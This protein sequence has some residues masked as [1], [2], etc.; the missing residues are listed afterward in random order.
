MS[1]INPLI[2]NEQERFPYAVAGIDEAGRGALAGPVVVS[3]VILSF[4]HPLERLNDSKLL[5]PRLRAELYHEIIQDAAAYSIIEIDHHYID[6]HNILQACF[7]GMRQAEQALSQ[8]AEKLII[9]GNMVPPGMQAEAIVKGDSL[10]ASIAA[11]SILAK[12]PRDM[13]MI[14]SAEFY[15]GYHFEKHKGYGTAQHIKAITSLGPSP[16]HRLSFSPLSEF[17]IWDRLK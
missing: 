10:F 5:N 8:K 15:P 12:V 13:L 11:A 17:M 9:D 1:N 3:A 2:K 4:N 14:R 6:Q 16:I 7:E